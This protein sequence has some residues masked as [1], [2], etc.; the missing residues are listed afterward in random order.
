MT[1]NKYIDDKFKVKVVYLLLKI[2]RFHNEIIE[3]QTEVKQIR[4]I[5]QSISSTTLSYSRQFCN[6]QNRWLDEQS[7]SSINHICKVLTKCLQGLE[8]LIASIRKVVGEQQPTTS[9]NNWLQSNTSYFQLCDIL[10]TA[11]VL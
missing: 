10:N 5:D 3:S 9:A 7:A 2:L 4:R 8:N 6:E 11:K 1:S